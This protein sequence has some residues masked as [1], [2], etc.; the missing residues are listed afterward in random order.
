MWGSLLG[1]PQ[2]VGFT[3][4]QPGSRTEPSGTEVDQS[5]QRRHLYRIRLWISFLFFVFFRSRSSYFPDLFLNKI[6]CTL[7]VYRENRGVNRSKRRELFEGKETKL[8][9]SGLSC[10]ITRPDLRSQVSP[11][12]AGPLWWRP[13][14]KTNGSDLLKPPSREESS[15][16][17]R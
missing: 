9:S 15:W 4:Q 6:L 3:A 13:T 12:K 16:T 7:A 11:F 8:S 2:W 10:L 1:R 14:V 17:P 5:E